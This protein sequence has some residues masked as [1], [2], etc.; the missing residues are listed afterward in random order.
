MSLKL[1]VPLT[2]QSVPVHSIESIYATL[3]SIIYWEGVTISYT[4]YILTPRHLQKQNFLLSPKGKLDIS[5]IQH[6]SCCTLLRLL[7]EHTKS[8]TVVF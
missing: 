7:G 1:M 3:L 2:N 4:H 6:A 8:E 5:L